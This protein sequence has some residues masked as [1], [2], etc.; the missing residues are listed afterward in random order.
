M[1]T[2]GFRKEMKETNQY[3]NEV[4][5]LQIEFEHEYELCIMGRQILKANKPKRK[6]I[7]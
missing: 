6:L 2:F 5:I 1:V 7:I 3:Q 4:Q